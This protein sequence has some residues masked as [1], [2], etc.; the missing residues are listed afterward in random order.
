MSAVIVEP[1]SA[2]IPLLGAQLDESGMIATPWVADA[3]RASLAALHRAVVTN[4]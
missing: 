2:S 4:E 1:A 3:I